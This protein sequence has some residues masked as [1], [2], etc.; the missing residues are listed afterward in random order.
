MADLTFLRYEVQDDGVVLE[1][2]NFS[3]G[4]GKPT[5]Y[6][7]KLTDAELSGVTTLPQ[8]RTL[9]TAKLQRK[10]QASGVAT[11]LDGLIGATVTI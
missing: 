2:V 11:K 4:P 9:V 5:N 7:I 10:I 6:T 3:P 8:L 1:F